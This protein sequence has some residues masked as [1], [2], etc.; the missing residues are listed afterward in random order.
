MTFSQYIM[1]GKDTLIKILNKHIGALKKIRSLASFKAKL[2]IANGIFM[3]KVLYLLSLYGGC[4]DYLLSAI[5]KKTDRSNASN[6]RQ[7][8]NDTWKTV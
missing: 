4:P 2:N 5:Q 7:E 3:S 8:M 6:H 1:D